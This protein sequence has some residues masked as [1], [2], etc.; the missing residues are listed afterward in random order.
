MNI[1]PY[2]LL[3]GLLLTAPAMAIPATEQENLALLL[4]Q[5]DQLNATLQRA[6]RQSS[7]TPATRFFF[8]YPQA[9]ADMR[10]MRTGVE[11]Y[12]TPSR[13]Q[14]RTVLPL[15]GRYRQDQTP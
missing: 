14:P 7:F 8:D 10:A 4:S 11:H 5:F 3:P 9:Y 13:S 12:L 6:Q 15:M 1:S 2:L